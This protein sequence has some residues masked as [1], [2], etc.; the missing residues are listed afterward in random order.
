[1]KRPF[2]SVIIPAY[3]EERYIKSC[4]EA[5]INQDTSAHHEIIVVNNNSTDRTHEIASAF[6]VCVVN[7]T[8][9][10][11]ASARNAGASYA[12]GNILVFIDA[13]CIASPNHLKTISMAFKRY[14]NSVV[15]GSY[16]FY[17]AP[18]IV[19]WVIRKA[20]LYSHYFRLTQYIF[21]MQILIAG[22]FA[23]TKKAFFSVGGFNESIDD[24]N[25]SDDTELA[26]RLSKNGYT[27]NYVDT[28]TVSTS[29]RRMKQF[30]IKHQISRISTHYGYLLSSKPLF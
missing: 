1:M 4:L 10:G 25:H 28:I 11:V 7:E 15:A 3:N 19:Q 5:L 26:V 20:K 14:P 22:N 16:D 12:Q 21:D 2:V 9:K 24:T 27:I 6:G 18:L 30:S 17:D 23:I 8:K 29:Y 13:D